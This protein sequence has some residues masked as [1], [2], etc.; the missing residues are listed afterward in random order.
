MVPT[1][2]T[3]HRGLRALVTGLGL[4]LGLGLPLPG[5][6][7]ASPDTLR[8]AVASTANDTGIL[9]ALVDDFLAQHPGQHVE[10]HP[11]G[12]LAALTAGRQGKADL[13]ITHDRRSEEI[14]IDEGFGLS[15]TQ[16]MYD[17]FAIVGPPADPLNLRRESDL[18]AALRR[19]ALAKAEFLAPS[20]QSGTAR[21]L[22]QLWDAAGVTPDWPGYEVTGTSA[23]ATLRQAAQF[24]SYTLVDM[25][26][27]L[28]QRSQLA[29]RITPLYRDNPLL[30]NVYSALVVNPN[31]VKGARAD[32][33]QPFVDYLVSDRAQELIAHFG[34]KIFQNRL[35]TPAAQLD[36]GVRAAKLSIKLARQ[37]RTLQTVI[38]VALLLLALSISLAL[39]VRRVRRADTARRASEERFVLAVSGTSD[40]IWDWNLTNDEVYF[41]PRWKE[42]LG[43]V[44][45]DDE[46]EN[47][48][49]EWKQRIHPD[50]RELVLAILDSYLE[51]RSPHFTSQH[52]LRTKR[53]D[54][55]WVLERGKAQ[56]DRHGRATRFTGA[57]TDIT[58]H[59]LQNDDSDY[60]VLYDARTGLVNRSLLLDRINHARHATSRQGSHMILMVVH[61]VRFLDIVDTY[62]RGAGDHVLQEVAHRLRQHVRTADTVGHVGENE[63]GILLVDSDVNR[64]ILP[65]HRILHSL[66][67]PVTLEGDEVVP[68]ACIGVAVYP[69]HGDQAETLLQHALV[70]L[71]NARRAHTDYCVYNAHPAV[72]Q[73]AQTP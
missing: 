5:H 14:F 19:L 51:G 63:F 8:I 53:G 69:D 1:L 38:V 30:R 21:R 3:T 61:L 43:Y 12:A 31:R 17:E 56:W 22:T 54:Y 37:N 66:E 20:P 41:S 35:Y 10:L 52:R 65:L 25:G 45:Y 33:A 70:A 47:G 26:T 58:S 23:A 72:S 71:Y 55:I 32:L 4:G 24:D 9:Q 57:A 15:R 6:T 46:I 34:E 73:I 39:L 40:A 68:S 7:A 60:Q 28:S 2:I 18:S 36:P 64:A 44:G 11:A 42:I 67:Q 62:G 29:G 48:I 16:I 49:D 27:F 50:D 59:Q 13:V